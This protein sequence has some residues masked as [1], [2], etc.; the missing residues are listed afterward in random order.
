MIREIIGAKT[1]ASMVMPKKNKR[2]RMVVPGMSALGVL[3][4]AGIAYMAIKRS[5]N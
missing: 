1:L 2:K 5:K 4:G 3:A